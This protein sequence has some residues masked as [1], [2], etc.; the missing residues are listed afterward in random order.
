MRQ[1]QVRVEFGAPRGSESRDPA[2][3]FCSPYGISTVIER[4]FARMRRRERHMA[5][6]MPVLRQDDILKLSPHPV[7]DRVRLHVR[8][9]SEEHRRHRRS[10]CM[11][12][13][14]RTSV[15]VNSMTHPS[16]Q[17]VGIPKNIRAR[18][19]GKAR[20]A[21]WGATSPGENPGPCLFGY[22]VLPVFIAGDDS[23]SASDPVA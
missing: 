14:T 23:P 21:G 2:T 10:F 3:E 8:L 20:Y 9:P 1:V 4:L 16:L 12:T 18:Q 13:T 5:I 22:R 19:P 17:H 11:S 7:D 15:S 6:G